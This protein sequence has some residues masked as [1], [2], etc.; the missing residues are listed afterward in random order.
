MAGTAPRRPPGSSGD[1]SGA[2][3]SKRRYSSHERGQRDHARN[4]DADLERAYNA[5][6]AGGAIPADL[7]GDPDAHQFHSWGGEDAGH[8]AA[9][10]AEP[11][12]PSTSDNKPS[13]PA[14]RNTSSSKAS[15]P[16]AEGSGFLL[17]LI[18]YAMAINF[19]R[20]GPNQLKGWLGAK[21]L[22]R[23]YGAAV[24]S[25]AQP[26]TP[27]GPDHGFLEIGP[28]APGSPQP[29]APSAPGLLR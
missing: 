14:A 20:G 18:A 21:F 19:L 3:P 26:A 7:K 11:S 2:G 12:P 16:I 28:F 6:Q 24:T 15:G 1:A 8:P 27:A 17:G 13:P 29:S 23:P 22:N 25:Q 9:P 4:R 5:G 10:P